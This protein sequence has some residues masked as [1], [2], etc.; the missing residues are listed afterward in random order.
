M[1]N[2]NKL[3][4]FIIAI[5]TIWVLFSI[6]KSYI[7]DI[8]LNNYG[9]ETIGR[10]I[11]FKGISKTKGFEY[12][13]NVEGKLKKSES[14][15]GLEENIKLGDFYKVVY[16]PSNTNIKKIY[17]D[18]KIKDTVAILKAGFSREDIENMPK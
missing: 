2:N 5:C 17:S 4:Y 10:V 3:A 9:I 6:S 11:K 14:L 1:R 15:I 18:E 16:L 13:Y 8:K 7:N 12:I